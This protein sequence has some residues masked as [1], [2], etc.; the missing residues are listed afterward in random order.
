MSV[1]VIMMSFSFCPHL[2]RSACIV[3]KNMKNIHLELESLDS[4][5]FLAQVNIFSKSVFVWN[6]IVN[7]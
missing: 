7:S 2:I 1:L 4:A 3:R 5:D 6:E